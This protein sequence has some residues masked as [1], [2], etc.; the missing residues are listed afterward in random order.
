LSFVQSRILSSISSQP[1]QA[2]DAACRITTACPQRLV[3][4]AAVDHEERT[5]RRQRHQAELELDADEQRA[6]GAGEQPAEIESRW[7]P[8][9]R[10]HDASIRASRA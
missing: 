3:H 7:P 4:R 5:R 8:A 9:D 6:L 1:V 10:R 2:C